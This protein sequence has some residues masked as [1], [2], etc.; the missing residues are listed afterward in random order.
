MASTIT[1]SGDWLF[2]IGNERMTKG[3]GNLGT[4]ATGGIAVTPT[5]VGLG[6][7]DSLTIDPAG[8]Y[9]F[10]YS[11]SAGKVLAYESA[12]FTPAGTNSAP[13][14]TTTTNA[15]TTEP[16]YT[17]AGALTQ[18]TGATGIT[19][20]QAPTFT[21]TA[22]AAAALAE[23]GNGVDLSGTTFTFRALGR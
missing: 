9:T 1:L 12:A 11:A 10:F 5:Q 16:M 15:G 17:N 22:V 2:S 19:G 4:Y 13:T 3:T 14:I 7:I 21:G 8:G 6:V 23:V 18:T 20:V